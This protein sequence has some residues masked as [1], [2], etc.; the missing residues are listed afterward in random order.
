M[1]STI[2]K[3]MFLKGVAIF[4]SLKTEEILQVAQISEEVCF[5]SGQ[6]IFSE[7][8]PGDCLYFLIDGRVELRSAGKVRASVL[9]KASFGSYAILTQSPRYFTAVAVTDACALR[10][11]SVEFMDM[12]SDNPQIAIEMLRYLALKVVDQSS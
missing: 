7:G 11:P 10:L 4:S 1:I 6:V 12:L 2:D 8:D 9:S 3:A 5:K